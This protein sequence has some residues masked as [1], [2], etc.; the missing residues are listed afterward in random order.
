[1]FHVQAG[2]MIPSANGYILMFGIC[3]S[4]MPLTTQSFVPNATSKKHFV[5][6]IR[7]NSLLAMLG[8]ICR[9]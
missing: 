7:K 4:C 2:A 5:Q 6:D 1:M 9:G 3:Y 8:A